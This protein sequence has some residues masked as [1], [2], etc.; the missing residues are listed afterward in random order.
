MG[1]GGGGWLLVVVGEAGGR[2]A[3]ACHDCALSAC[4]DGGTTWVDDAELISPLMKPLAGASVW[5]VRAGGVLWEVPMTW[6]LLVQ[7][8]GK[9]RCAPDGTVRLLHPTRPA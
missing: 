6:C 8:F 4:S 9:I 1:G 2:F 3:R 7:V 5:R